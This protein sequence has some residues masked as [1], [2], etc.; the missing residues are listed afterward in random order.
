MRGGI[1]EVPP[2][3]AT[4][5]GLSPRARGNR[6]ESCC[7]GNC[8]RSIPACAGE[9]HPH[10]QSVPRDEVYPRVR[11][12]IR[13]RVLRW[14]RY[15]GLSPR[16][17]GNRDHVRIRLPVGGSIP[18]CAGESRI[19]DCHD[20]ATKV[21]PR[22]RGG[23]PL[24]GSDRLPEQGLSPRARGNPRLSQP[25]HRSVRSIPA[26][27]GESLIMPSLSSA[28]QVYPRVRGGIPEVPP[29]RATTR[30]LSPRA[31]GNRR[32]V[33]PC[34][35]SLS[36][37]S[38]RAR[39]NPN[40]LTVGPISTGS[41]PACAGESGSA[42]RQSWYAKVYPRVR[43]GINMRTALTI[44]AEGLSPRAR[45]NLAQQVL[46]VHV[47]RSIPACAGESLVIKPLKNTTLLKN[48]R[49]KPVF[50]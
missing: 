6:R 14:S 11:G 25:T 8:D 15:R 2:R 32:S 28:I 45:G 3:R 16:A 5:K 23:I 44:S 29:R 22:V 37:L 47:D 21:Y 13:W 43:G 18:A 46:A 9:S 7:G 27:A 4:T 33:E 26:C 10:T 40:L 1:P 41:I 30:G 38:P 34:Q 35:S 31:R 48:S 17:R 36:G 12:G 50:G 20:Y 24:R 49:F 39:G 19:G 42:R